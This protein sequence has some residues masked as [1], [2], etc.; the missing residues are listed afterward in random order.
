MNRLDCRSLL[1]ENSDAWV[2]KQLAPEIYGQWRTLYQ[3]DTETWAE[4]MVP[5]SFF[6]YPGNYFLSLIYYLNK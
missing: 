1:D 3:R 2:V 4:F 5:L 6:L